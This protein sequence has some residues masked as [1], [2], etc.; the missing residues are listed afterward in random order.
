MIDIQQNLLTTKIYRPPLPADCV[1]RSDLLY[2]LDAGHSRPL[3]LISAPAGYGKSVLASNWLETS[4]WASVWVSLDENDNDLKQFLSYLSAAVCERFTQALKTT[5]SL[6]NAATLPETRIVSNIVSNELNAIEQPFFIVL[7]DYQRIH[8]GSLVN[9][10]LRFLL[11]QPPIPLHLVLLTRRDPPLALNRLRALGQVTDIRMQDLRF[12]ESETRD[13]LERGAHIRPSEES[14]A[15]LDR[16]LEGWVAGL[17]LMMLALRRSP[18]ADEFMKRFNSGTKQM[19]EYLISE[20]VAGLPKSFRLWLLRS[21]LFDRFC[22]SLCQA[23]CIEA[24]GAETNAITGQEF[25]EQ[26]KESNLFV[27]SLDDHGHWFRFHHLFQKL[28]QR[29]LSRQVDAE[30]IAGLHMRASHWFEENG[31]IDEAIKAAVNTGDSDAAA[32]IVER[33]WRDE[34]E[35]FNIHTIEHWLELLGSV[36]ARGPTLLLTEAFVCF[37]QYKQSRLEAILGTLAPVIEKNPDYANLMG[38]LR[39]LQGIMFFRFGDVKTGRKLLQEGRSLFGTKER[40]GIA[41]MAIFHEALSLAHSGHADEA[42]TQVEDLINNVVTDNPIYHCFLISALVIVSF[43][44]GD[45]TR[46]VNEAIRLEDRAQSCGFKFS[47]SLSIY[48]RSCSELQRGDFEA[49]AQ[50]FETFIQQ[51]YTVPRHR[52]FDT[53]AG[54]ALCHQLLQDERAATLAARNLRN[55]TRELNDAY[56]LEIARSCEARIQLMQGDVDRAARWAEFDSR[57]PEF[58]AMHYAMEVPA[59]VRS[60]VWV[61][62][63]TKESLDRAYK[64]LS[65]IGERARHWHFTNHLI[66][67]DVLKSLALA[68]LGRK[69]EALERLAATVNLA[70]PG[71]W[72]RPFLETGKPMADL[73]M[74]LEG[75]GLATDFSRQ[76]ESE[77]RGWCESQASHALTESAPQVM[78]E[79]GLYETM[80]PRELD[81]LELL[82]Q[83]LQNK[84]I[85]DNLFVSPETIKSHLKKIYQKLGVAKR[86]EA[87]EKARQIGII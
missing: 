10:V 84:E 17:R 83:R 77:I 25:I 80:T 67:A 46:S 75:H 20:V 22:G 70:A 74:Q 9:N 34:I 59:I 65:D 69:D 42:L 36:T 57:P 24:D 37:H 58:F 52:A 53:M 4:D 87:V 43:F 82:A 55:F 11:D 41:A 54:F 13:L 2:L 23:V 47:H 8:A 56:G 85:S 63:G 30:T 33:Q 15:N 45:L 71:I 19:Q 62:L 7:D 76:I 48:F 3:T 44:R 81:V 40:K 18:D 68:G 49:A 31:M 60:R 6:S 5:R 32:N 51:R 50:R 72:I 79:A 27:I 21:A 26:L 35:K 39:C 14:L 12:S 73:L 28:L 29:E 1:H 78:Q 16:K 86:Q 38:E 64:L 61:A 66:E